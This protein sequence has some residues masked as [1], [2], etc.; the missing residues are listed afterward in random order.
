M[1]SVPQGIDVVGV[2]NGSNGRNCEHHSVCGHFVMAGDFLFCKWAIQKFDDDTPES[3]V[4][5]HKLADDGHV[6]CHVGYLPRRLIRASRVS[7]DGKKKKDG[8]KKYDGLWL[9]VI[10]DLRLSDNVSERARSHRNYG[11]V[12]CHVVDDEWLLGKN[13]FE[14]TIEIPK[15]VAEKCFELPPDKESN[16]DE[17]DTDK[18]DD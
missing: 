2:D 8:G 9:K 1:A 6:G 11:M 4:Q 5:V 15:E 12:Y 18:E 16:V 17:Y 13:P 10:N 7:T 3:C 14:E